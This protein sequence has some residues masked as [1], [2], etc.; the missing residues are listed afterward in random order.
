MLRDPHL[1][2]SLMAVGQ[3]DRSAY[4]FA[5]F[6]V[7]LRSPPRLCASLAIGACWSVYNRSSLNH[8]RVKMPGASAFRAPMP[9]QARQINRRGLRGLDGFR[10]LG[11][12]WF[13]HDLSCRSPAVSAL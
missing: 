11:V 13:T 9:N 1:G 2:H 3:F 7:D 4:S 12:L 6:F 8:A 10:R 5:F